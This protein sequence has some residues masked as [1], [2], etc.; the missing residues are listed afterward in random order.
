MSIRHST[1]KVR[2]TRALVLQ[3]D[4]YIADPA[5]PH[6][7]PYWAASLRQDTGQKKYLAFVSDWDRA[8][9]TDFNEDWPDVVSVWIGG[10]SFEAPISQRARID[11][12]IAENA[13]AMD[14]T[15]MGVADVH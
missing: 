3:L 4:R 6:S 10:A 9:R 5:R 7:R 2:I 11:G 12:W 8:P 15:P 14:P 13:N 1:L